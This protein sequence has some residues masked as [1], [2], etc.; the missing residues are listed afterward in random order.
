MN[1][2][3]VAPHGRQRI[4]IPFKVPGMRIAM[5]FYKR[6]NVMGGPRPL[7]YCAGKKKNRGGARSRELESRVSSKLQFAAAADYISRFNGQ[8]GLQPLLFSVLLSNL[9]A[10]PVCQTC[11]H[12]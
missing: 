1:L 5:I 12:S 3:D 4:Q 11:P 10:P 9:L 7:L 6:C 8:P 2:L